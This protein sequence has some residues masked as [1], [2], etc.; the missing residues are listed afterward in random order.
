MPPDVGTPF[1]FGADDEL[2]GIYHRAA[3]PA[4]KAVLLCPPLGQDLIRCHRL[5]RQLAYAL[6]VQG[7]DVLRFDYFGSGDSEGS[8]ADLDWNRCIANTL[9][10]V[11]KLRETNSFE[12]LI[13]FGARLGGSILLATSP[14][15]RFTE[16][17]VWD[18]VLDGAAHVARL[19]ELQAAVRLDRNRF[20]KPRSAADAA[21]QWA[22]FAIGTHLRQ[23]LVDLHVNPPANRTTLFHSSP[24]EHDWS[25]LAATGTKVKPLC[26]APSW[27]DLDRLELA[28]LSPELIQAVSN[29][30]REG[31]PC[32]NTLVDSGALRIS[33]A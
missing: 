12:Q 11:S 31:V 15:T 13:G 21:G 14:A 25:R 9:A 29:E 17:I 32:R 4:T 10:A 19:D 28:I 26:Q 1:Y 8:S 16:L 23:Q 20:L 18:P 6:V 27:D 30:L 33:S 3:A 24:P 2:F 7:C 22:G 5:Y